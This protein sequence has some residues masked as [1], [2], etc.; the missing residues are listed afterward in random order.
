MKL[1]PEISIKAIPHKSQRYEPVGDYFKKRGVWLFRISRM[2][3][4]YVF[5]VIVHEIIEWWLCQRAGIKN[6]DIDKFDFMFEDE[7]KAGKHTEEEE[8]GND[9][10]APYFSQHAFATTIE[11]ECC[12]KMGI[13]WDEYSTAIMKL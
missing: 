6:S 9:M 3:P 12:K 11:E 7:R 13:D 4:D 8:A 1:F 2:K 10:R 5:L